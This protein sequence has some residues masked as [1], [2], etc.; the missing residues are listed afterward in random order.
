MAADWPLLT[1]GRY[2]EVAVRTGLTVL[3]SFLLPVGVDNSRSIFASTVKPVYN[4][5]PLD[6][7]IVAVVL[8]WLLFRGFSIKIGIKFDLAGLR[9]A[10]VSRWPLFRGGR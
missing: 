10:V 6:P 9:L 7:K 4:G 8:R 2:S 1:G 3:N 5:H